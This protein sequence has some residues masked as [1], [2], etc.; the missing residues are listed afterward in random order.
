[1]NLGNKLSII[2]T[3]ISI[4]A[5]SVCM[6]ISRGEDKIPPVIT[7]SANRLVYSENI[8]KDK[9]LESVSAMDDRDGDVT[10]TVVIEKLTKTSD[11]KGVIITYA[12][13]DHS[14]N[15]AKSSR[16]FEAA[17]SVKMESTEKINAIEQKQ[18]TEIKE[19]E[20]EIEKEHSE[21]TS[22]TE[23]TADDTSAEVEKPEDN[24]VSQEEVL[25][26]API[27]LLNTAETTLHKG[28]FFNIT[29]YIAQLSDDTDTLD[30]LQYKIQTNGE[31][32]NNTAGDYQVNV[33]VTD[34]SGN[35][36]EPQKLTIHVTE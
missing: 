15:F 33:L 27:L 34:S 7:F 36:S 31:F 14:N 26:Q 21:E 13:R 29:D 25:N 35:Q 10:D 24:K 1:M 30:T 22:K 12:A 19:K 6:F 5:L 11:G 3:S 23:D 4:L 8:E 32:D 2:L 18:E 20:E 16:I 28:D 17:S 9:L